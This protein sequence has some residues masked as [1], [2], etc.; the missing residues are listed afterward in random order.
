MQSELFLEFAS[1][2]SFISMVLDFFLDWSKGCTCSLSGGL[3]KQMYLI[4]LGTSC[5]CS[6]LSQGNFSHNYKMSLLKNY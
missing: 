3:F 2:L 1:I 6:L 5:N 4:I